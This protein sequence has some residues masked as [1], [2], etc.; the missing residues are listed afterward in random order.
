MKEDHTSNMDM[1][2]N[3]TGSMMIPLDTPTHLNTQNKGRRTSIL[4]DSN[5]R[6]TLDDKSVMKRRVSFAPT[7]HVRLDTG[8]KK[9]L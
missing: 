3:Q 4:V 6:E 1:T 9:N 2:W 7:A 5:R 8:M